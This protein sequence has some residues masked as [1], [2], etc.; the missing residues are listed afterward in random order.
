[1]LRPGGHGGSGPA[2][3]PGLAVTALAPVQSGL[4]ACLR[5]KTSISAAT[6]NSLS[7]EGFAPL[8]ELGGPA[9]QLLR[10]RGHL[11]LLASEL[12]PLF[13]P[14]WTSN[15]HGSSNLT[16]YAFQ[17]FV[18]VEYQGAGLPDTE[19]TVS[20]LLPSSSCIPRCLNAPLRHQR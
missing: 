6:R 18:P 3:E 12:R 9:R 11:H 20:I 8:R 16:V 7:L 17:G 14:P 2:G 13:R 1:M 5:R 10:F 4:G 19:N 15:H